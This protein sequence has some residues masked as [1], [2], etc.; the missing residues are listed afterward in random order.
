[1]NVSKVEMD[2][3]SNFNRSCFD[4]S[5]VNSGWVSRSSRYEGEP[6]HLLREQQ[7]IK[8]LQ[9]ANK[10]KITDNQSPNSQDL[11]G[12]IDTFDGKVGGIYYYIGYDNDAP[13]SFLS[14]L[15]FGYSYS[16]QIPIPTKTDHKS[17]K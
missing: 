11:D 15:E 10:I 9:G 14:D 13:I 8:Y 16:S 5:E 7:T 3:N 1:M 6:A 4:F 17:C 12:K 2:N